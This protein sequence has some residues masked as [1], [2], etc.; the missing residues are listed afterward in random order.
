MH[1]LWGKKKKDWEEF[2]RKKLCLGTKKEHIA[3]HQH[4]L[5]PNCC[6]FRHLCPTPQVVPIVIVKV[7]LEL[8]RVKSR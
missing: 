2:T 3:K 4:K 6:P 5:P 8:Q 7:K 1:I